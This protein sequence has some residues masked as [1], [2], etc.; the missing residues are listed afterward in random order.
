MID[1]V[2]AFS[3]RNRALVILAA[4]ALALGGVLAVFRTPVDA[5]PDLSENQVIVFTEWPGHSPREIE[6]QVTYPLSLQLQGLSGVRVVRSSSDVGFSMISV[7]FDDS[8]PMPA[9]RRQVAERLAGA[10]LGLPPGVV[11]ALGPDA[12]A[13][14]QVFWYT[15][16]GTGHDLGRLRA[17]QDWYVRPQLASVP[18]VA[19]V[20]SVGGFPIEYQV[21]VDPRK[22]AARGV[23]L[24][25]VQGAVARSNAAVGG[26]VVHKA[27]AAFVVRGVGGLGPAPDSLEPEDRARRVLA[28]LQAVVVPREGGTTVRLAE[29]AAVSLGSRP[30]RGMLEK[31]GNEVV[32]GVVMMRHGE[33]PLEITRRLKHKTLE[34]RSGLP[35]GV[36]IVPCYDRTPLIESAVGTVRTTL[37][38]AIL[39][40]TLCVV[41]VLRHLRTSFVITLT[42]PLTVLMSF[43]LMYMLRRLGIV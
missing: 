4:A 10:G 17:I 21:E 41:V 24:Q 27:N 5:I 9:A 23:S 8:V 1:S 22:L 2:I 14:G 29:V 6:D 15:V 12:A 33:N 31:D 3:I 11:P 16:E 30:R 32:G 34:L 40:A 39:T 26:D 25:A 18:G 36:R 35:E 42:L 38:E 19:E 43:G 37:I 13:T 20:A 7:I 28:D